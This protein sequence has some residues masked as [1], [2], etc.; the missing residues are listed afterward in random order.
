MD[1]K[2]EISNEEGFKLS[3][4]FKINLIETSALN[5]YNINEAFY[6][7]IENIYDNNCINNIEDSEFIY[8]SPPTPKIENEKIC[9]SCT[10]CSS[11]IEIL[12]IDEKNNSM[13]FKCLNNISHGIKNISL[14]NYLEKMKENKQNNINEYKVKCKNHIDNNFTH[15]CLDCNIHLCKEC[16]GSR[17]HL[18]HRKNDIIE[19]KPCEKEINIINK[20]IKYCKNNLKDLKIE[21]I[22]KTEELKNILKKGENKEKQLLKN[23]IKINDNNKKVELQLNKQ[24]YLSDLENLKKEYEEKI[25]SRKNK[26]IEDNKI[27]Y[28][29]YRFLRQKEEMHNKIKI[30]KLNKDYLN[31]LECFQF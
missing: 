16:F 18:N 10:E 9:F 26:Y 5:G 12:T 20:V 28:N 7:L 30:E 25:E 23:K 24:Q 15:F 31:D 21:K 3:E 6:N 13:N 22:N 1:N 17:I 4:K 29:K 11:A 14:K 2:R 19:M 8:N 27:I